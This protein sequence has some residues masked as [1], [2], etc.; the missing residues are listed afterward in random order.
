MLLPTVL[1]T[2][3]GVLARIYWTMLAVTEMNKPYWDAHMEALFSTI[4]ALVKM[5]ESNVKVLKYIQVYCLSHCLLNSQIPCFD[6]K[7]LNSECTYCGPGLSS[8]HILV[9]LS[10]SPLFIFISSHY[11]LK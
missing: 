1:P 10:N 6:F 5:Q 4:V 8:F 3:G 7:E 2:L 11:S 9:S